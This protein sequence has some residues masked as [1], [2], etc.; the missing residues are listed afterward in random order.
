MDSLPQELIDLISSYLDIEDLKNTLT[1]SQAFQVAAEKYSGAYDHFELNED[2]KSDF[3]EIFGGRRLGYLQHLSFRTTLPP[4]DDEV[5]LD[6]Q[7]DGAPIRDTLEDL[8]EVDESF[9]E[10]VKSLFSTI[11]SAEDRANTGSGRIKLTI[12]TPTRYIDHENYSIQRAYVSWRVHLLSP[13]ALPSLASV[14]GLRIENGMEWYYY[15]EW[16]AN[17][18]R[19]LDLRVIADLSLK[20]PNLEALHCGIGGDE[21]LAGNVDPR[22]RYVTKDWAGPRRDSRHSFAQAIEE[23]PISKLRVARLNFIAP[24]SL[25]HNF[26]QLEAFPNLIAPA[27]Y[28]LFSSNLRLLSYQLRKL[29]LTAIL[30]YTFFWPIDGATP[31]WPNLEVLNVTFHIMTPSGEWYFNPLKHGSKSGYAITEADYPPYEETDPDRDDVDYID[32]ANIIRGQNRVVPNNDTLVP[33]LQSFAKAAA[34]MPRLK[35]ALLWAPLQLSGADGLNLSSLTKHAKSAKSCDP[36]AWGL[37]YSSSDAEG[38]MDGRGHR[39][40]SSRQIWWQV[41]N[42]RPD[43]ALHSMIKEIGKDRHGENLLEYWHE[44]WEDDRNSTSIAGRYELERFEEQLFEDD[45]PPAEPL[46]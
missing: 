8:R 16:D 39:V 29:S 5:D 31:S 20:L 19:K 44:Y 22:Q 18:L 40:E 1:V 10:Q 15:D 26:D 21:W 25:A 2:N 3:I 32:W 14:R 4:L 45:W 38:F 17:S 28:D 35:Q 12:Y 13:K 33:L 6:E 34:Y 46:S 11:K 24:L 7:P 37:V 23:H 9:T 30:D 36:L 41:A 42:W 43:P 27:K